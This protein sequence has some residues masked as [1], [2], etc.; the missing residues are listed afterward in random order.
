MACITYKE[1]I[2]RSN[3]RRIIDESNTI[4]EH[5]YSQG[6]VMT[7]RQLYYQLVKSNKIP[8]NKNSYNNLGNVI[9]DARLAGYIDW[10]YLED[11]GRV[12][13]GIRHYAS[14]QQVLAEGMESYRIDM[15]E[16]QTVR[17]EV[18]IEKD[19]LSGVFEGI[20]AEL[21]VDLL[22]CKGYLSL[23]EAHEAAKRFE[24]IASYGQTPIVFHFGDHDSSGID[25][26]RDILAKFN[27]FIGGAEV[28]RRAL[29]M[30][31]IKLYDLPPQPA[32]MSDPRAENYRLLHGNESWEL[33]S[34]DPQQLTELVRQA[35]EGVRDEDQWND[36][37]AR[38]TEER[39]GLRVVNKHWIKVVKY[40]DKL[41]KPKPPRK[42][43]KKAAKKRK[44]TKKRARKRATKK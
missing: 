10:D 14:P 19:A 28:D 13:R 36:A 12:L 2:F 6:F 34:L 8:N 11:R 43:R 27:L 44:P 15:W 21:D 9:G 37:V 29:T 31:Q 25:M 42:P 26:T 22:A 23:S 7:L 16:N 3:S 24:R 33:D 41:N 30:D 5:F 39:D 17:P 18:W 1:Q 32:K 40:A 38:E 35:V 4:L 20:C